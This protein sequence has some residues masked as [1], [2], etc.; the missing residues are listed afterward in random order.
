MRR[1][2]R[3]TWRLP[4]KEQM[5]SVRA[6]VTHTAPSLSTAQP[7]TLLTGARALRPTAHAGHALSTA[8]PCTLLTVARALC[9]LQVRASPSSFHSIG[10]RL[11][12]PS[13]QVRAATPSTPSPSSR[14][15]STGTA[16]AA[17]GT[18]TALVQPPQSGAAGPSPPQRT[19]LGATPAVSGGSGGRPMRLSAS[20]PALAPARPLKRASTADYPRS[21]SM[22]TSQV[23]RQQAR[24]STEYGRRGH[25]ASAGP[26]GSRDGGTYSG[27]TKEGGAAHAAVG[28]AAHAAVADGDRWRPNVSSIAALEGTDSHEGEVGGVLGLLAAEELSEVRRATIEPHLH[29]APPLLAHQPWPTIMAASCSLRGRTCSTRR[30]SGCASKSSCHKRSSTRRAS[31][32]RRPA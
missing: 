2:Y 18:R 30:R 24:P 14:V 23:G 10:P 27:S 16:A 11:Q 8:Q 4:L 13:W 7:C 9:V 32:S 5:P 20:M 21:S 6:R 12:P 19:Q 29:P 31:N 22:L 1:N 25:A 3:D 26:L 28:G 17:V 15:T